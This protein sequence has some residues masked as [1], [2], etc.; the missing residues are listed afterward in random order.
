MFI[1]IKYPIFSVWHNKL[2]YYKRSWLLKTNFCRISYFS[3]TCMLHMY[4]TYK[5]PSIFKHFFK[6]KNVERP[7]LNSYCWLHVPWVRQSP[8]CLPGAA[9]PDSRGLFGKSRFAFYRLRLE[10]RGSKWCVCFSPLNLKSVA[11]FVNRP[12]RCFRVLLCLAHK[13]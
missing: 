6:E 2:H 13:G 5:F 4:N 7:K 11:I 12:L 10:G 1:F 3:Y 9:A 8:I